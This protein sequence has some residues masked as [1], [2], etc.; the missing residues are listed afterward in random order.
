MPIVRDEFC[1]PKVGTAS[2]LFRRCTFC[3]D[4]SHPRFS[5]HMCFTVLPS[6]VGLEENVLLFS[7]SP[8]SPEH[9]GLCANSLRNRHAER[10]QGPQMDRG[11]IP[12]VFGESAL[13][14]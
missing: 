11:S 8:G 14:K 2:A 7:G 5:E 10:K 6:G 9:P 4:H 3:M 13:K 12:S 1:W